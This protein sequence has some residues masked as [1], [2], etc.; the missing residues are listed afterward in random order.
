M[1]MTEPIRRLLLLL[2]ALG[3]CSAVFGRQ[4]SRILVVTG[5]HPFHEAAFY[6]MLDSFPGIVY[7]TISHPRAL[8]RLTPAGVRPYDA[9]LFYDMPSQITPAQQRD[10]LRMARR[11]KGLVFLHHALCGYPY[12]PGYTELLGGRYH[13]FGKRWG[14]YRQPVSGYR[15]NV[16]FRVQV[17]DSLHPVTAGIGEFEITDET[18]RD[19]E[20]TPGIHPLLGTRE[21]SSCPLLG[22]T[23]RYGRSRI[24]VLTLGHDNRA[25]NHPSFGRLLARSL[26][27]CGKSETP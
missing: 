12:W 16:R 18:Y 15:M 4:P 6:A 13:T 22:W 5:G 10:F 7:D 1:R 17:R 27:W 25:W 20:L 14:G 2:F 11:G 23:H 24:V 19:L 9:V 26:A 8:E 21:A 3:L